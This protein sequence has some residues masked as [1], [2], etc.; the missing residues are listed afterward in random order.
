M[1]DFVPLSVNAQAAARNLG[2]IFDSDLT[3]KPHIKK[4]VHAFST[5]KHGLGPS[6]IAELLTPLAGLYLLFQNPNL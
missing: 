3:F 6:Y 5:S 2:V 4:T 1:N